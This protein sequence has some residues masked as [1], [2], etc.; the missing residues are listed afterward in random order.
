LHPGLTRG[1]DGGIPLRLAA[2]DF[3]GT[4]IGRAVGDDTVNVAS[5]RPPL[6]ATGTLS[7]DAAALIEWAKQEEAVALVLGLPL[8]SDGGETKMSRVCRKLGELLAVHIP[9]HMVDEWMT[10][11]EAETAMVD[12]GLKGSQRRHAS[13]GEAACRILE[14]FMEQ[15]GESG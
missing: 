13:D 2:I 7:K 8:Q 5:P 14:R 10:S 11:H 1:G 3:G 4:R 9:V 15:R 12:A 6:T